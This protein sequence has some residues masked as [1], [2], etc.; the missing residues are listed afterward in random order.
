MLLQVCLLFW[1]LSKPGQDALLWSLQTNSVQGDNNSDEDD[2]DRSSDNSS[3]SSNRLQ[4]HVNWYVGG[5][6]V[7][8]R[9]FLRMLGVG[10]N[11]INRTRDRFKGLDERKVTGRGGK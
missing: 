6:R 9:A 2:D 10:C 7:C 5:T 4:H 3:S 1:G 8:R 11:R